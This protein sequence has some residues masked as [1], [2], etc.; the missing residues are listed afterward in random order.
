MDLTFAPKGV[1]NSFFEANV[2]SF[3]KA[4]EAKLPSAAIIWNN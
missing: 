4:Y 2:I 3:G 1:L